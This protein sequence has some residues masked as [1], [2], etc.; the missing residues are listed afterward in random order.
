MK[1]GIVFFLAVVIT[2]SS[3]ATNKK[4]MCP[5]FHTSTGAATV[6]RV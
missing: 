1:G 6:E 2:L 5:R 3:C 4:C